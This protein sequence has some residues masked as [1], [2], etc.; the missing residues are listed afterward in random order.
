MRRKGYTDKQTGEIL[1]RI[2]DDPEDRHKSRNVDSRVVGKNKA[3]EEK[4]AKRRKK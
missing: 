2:V 1:A 4:L 3:Y